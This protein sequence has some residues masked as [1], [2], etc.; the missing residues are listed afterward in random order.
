MHIDLNEATPGTLGAD[1]AVIGAGAA[2]ITMVRR[3]LA[4]GLSVVLLESGGVDYEPET[5]DLNDGPIMG[6]DYYE[7]RDAR[8]RFFGG[9]TAIWGGRCA[10]LA[11]IDFQ[12]RAWV[13][14]SGWPITHADV[15]PYYAEA[16]A[17]FGLDRIAPTAALLDGIL[18]DF[19]PRELAVPMWSFD[20]MFDRFSFSRSTDLVDHDRCT[21]VTHATVRE[22]VAAPSA[23]GVDRLAVTSLSGNALEVRAR[24]YVLAAGGIENPRLLLASRSVRPRGL[25]N[26]RDQ[27]GRYFM[28]HPHARGGRVVDG[29]AWALLAAFQKREVTGRTIAPLLTPS[30]G[31]QAREGLL[32]TSLTIAGRRPA[33]GR[34]ALLMRAY[35]R[36][37]HK[38]A[39]TRTGRTMWKATK[40]IVGRAQ[41]LV[42][43]LRPWVLNRLGQL[44]VALIVRA[45][46]APNP[47]SRVTLAGD[48]DALG[49]P[50]AALDWRMSEL[51]VT[52]VAGLVAALGRETERLGLGRVE[53]AA[54]L[55]D[56]ARQWRSDPLISVHALGG[57][58]HVGTTRMSDDPRTGVTDRE[59][60]VHGIDNLYVAGSSLFPTSGW[61]NPTL[62]IAALALRQ[63]DRIA[64]TL[65]GEDAARRTQRAA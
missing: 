57:Y 15:A 45:E 24:R 40:Q 25:G 1:V 36:A 41:R 51:D 2:G 17:A 39:P 11:P 54:W 60:R 59:G 46:Q 28:E 7:L 58:H 56:P 32:N 3:L 43:P 47:D 22:I 31:L 19:S 26:D 48:S 44:D 8:L 18:P 27:V 50:R 5:A 23:E 21:V 20:A 64:A 30:A 6:E 53:P 35:Q 16:R 63:A 37:K 14:H 61:A 62:T 52:S 42:D 55:S 29:G 38:S 65:A 34:E 4:Q 13:P 9:T 10:E 49:V 12:K 33:H